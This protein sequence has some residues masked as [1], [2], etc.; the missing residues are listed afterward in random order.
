MAI[1]ELLPNWME[2][3]VASGSQVGFTWEVSVGI[4]GCSTSSFDS[5][6]DKKVLESSEF[7]RSC[8]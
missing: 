4:L 3:M 8:G 1:S 2:M 7:A 5:S 6:K